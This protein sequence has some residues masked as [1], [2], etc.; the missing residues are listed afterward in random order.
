MTG[1]GAATLDHEVEALSKDE[2]ARQEREPG[3]CPM[4]PCGL[5]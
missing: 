4:E 3:F 2:K 1:A 5:F